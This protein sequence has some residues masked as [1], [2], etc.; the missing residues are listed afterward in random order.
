MSILDKEFGENEESGSSK[1]S[2]TEFLSI[3][4]LQEGESEMVAASKTNSQ[5]QVG[6]K[7]GKNGNTR[8]ED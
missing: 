8:T 4:L 7:N 5:V 3:K 1:H 6:R 2:E